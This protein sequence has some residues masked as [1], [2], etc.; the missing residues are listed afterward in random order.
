MKKHMNK[1]KLKKLFFIFVLILG[2]F[3]C[4]TT[5][6][7]IPRSTSISLG[8]VFP[9]MTGV[10]L[11]AYSSVKLKRKEKLIPWK[12]VRVAVMVIVCLGI[13][14]FLVIEGIIIAYANSDPS[15][16]DVNYCIVL[17][18]GIFP[19]GRISLSLKSRLDNAV[20]YLNEHE[21]VICIVSGGKGDTEP[22]AEAFAMKDYLVEMGIDEA[23]ILTEANSY[24]THD[25]MTLSAKLM[26]K[27]HPE[28]EKTAV[29][30][31]NDFHIFRSIAIAKNRG[32]TGYGI[33]CYTPLFVKVPSYMREFLTI[34][35]TF[36][37][38][39]N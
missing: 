35:N 22:V 30:I 1:E 20:E 6:I 33:P 19:D 24:S 13:A 34:I 2:C 10:V 3:L 29:I 23:R 11:I 28:L 15:D 21:D 31:T 37:F 36:L 16:E 9:A 4:L 38:Q 18:A 5:I 17:G 26:E 12:G 39:M 7:A 32:I 8:T 14:L 25:N 27:A